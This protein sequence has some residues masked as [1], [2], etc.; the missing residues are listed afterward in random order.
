MTAAAP[1]PAPSLRSLKPVVARLLLPSVPSRPVGPSPLRCLPACLSDTVF[2]FPLVLRGSQSAAP[3]RAHV[4]SARSGSGN[5]NTSHVCVCPR[6]WLPGGW[7][8]GGGARASASVT[9]GCV[10]E[11]PAGWVF[12]FF[13]FSSLFL[14]FSIIPISFR[15]KTHVTRDV[16]LRLA[17]GCFIKRATD[18]TWPSTHCWHVVAHLT[19]CSCVV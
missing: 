7:R 13:F 4:D 1:A 8:E 18:G 10:S 16:A 12:F 3:P 5:N 2:F 6:G 9:T 17:V 11:R 19:W 14:S 15:S